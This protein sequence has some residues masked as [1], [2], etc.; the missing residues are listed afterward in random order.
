MHTIRLTF[1]FLLSVFLLLLLRTAAV[2]AP[3]ERYAVVQLSSLE[4]A[5]SLDVTFLEFVPPSGYLVR[6]PEN[7]R[8]VL[9]SPLVVTAEPILPTQKL[10]SDAKV[11]AITVVPYRDVASADLVDELTAAGMKIEH[12]GDG[13]VHGSAENVA[14]I[15]AV[16]DVMWVQGRARFQELNDDASWLV[17]SGK[18]DVFSLYNHGVTGLGQVGAAADSGMAVYDFLN[19]GTPPSCFFDDGGQLPSLTHRKVLS[20]YVPAGADADMKDGSGHGSHVVGTIVGDAGT[21]GERDPFDGIAYDAR[22]FFQDIGKNLEPFPIGTIN[23]PSDFAILFGGAYDPN[24]DGVYQPASEP[25]THSNS[26]GGVEP[27]YNV[28]TA[29]TDAFMWQHPDFLIFYAAGNQGPGANTVG[30]PAVAKNIVT[31][32]GT[33]NGFAYPNNMGSFSSHGP[34]PSG[35]MK[36]TLSAPGDRVRSVLADDPCGTIHKSGTSM[37]TPATH[38]V[39]LLMRQY[40]WDGYYPTGTPNVAN[41]IH[42]SAALLKGMLM[43]SAV[44]LSGLY[45]DNNG[46]G[47]WPSNGQGWGRVSADNVLYFPGDQRDLWLHDEYAL[48]G[49]AGFNAI[50]QT[51]TFTLTVGDGAPFAPQPLAIHLVWTDY[52]SAMV[53]NGALVNNLD[54]TV[55]SPSGSIHYGNDPLTND[56]RGVPDLPTRPDTINPWEGVYLEMPESG[57]YTITVRSGVLGSLMLDSRKQGFALVATGDFIDEPRI[58]FQF[59]HYDVGEPQF[60]ELRVVDPDA[61]GFVVAAV[62][63]A[64]VTLR[65]SETPGIFAG[66]VLLTE[67]NGDVAVASYG[68]VTATTEIGRVPINNI[69]PPVVSASRN[70]TLSW[71]SAE[72]SAAPCGSPNALS[73]YVVQASDTFTMPL[74]DDAE[75]GLGN[76]TF[77]NEHGNANWTTNGDY[78]TSGA[79][80]FYSG[81][82]DDLQ[83]VNRSLVWGRPITLP[84]TLTSARLTY[85]SRYFNY[86]NDSGFIELS[87]DDGDTWQTIKEEYA[88]TY[89]QIPEAT[90]STRMQYRAIDLS[91][92]IGQPFRVRF[93]FDNMLASVAPGAPGWWLDDVRIEGGSWRTVAIVEG[94]SAEMLPY[95]AAYRVQAVFDDGSATPFSTA[96][97]PPPPPTAV[98]LSSAEA[99]TSGWAVGLLLLLTLTVLQFGRSKTTIFHKGRGV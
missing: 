2:A 84:N 55:T 91:D 53:A 27:V 21:H 52:A 71:T 94:E 15:A 29:Q 3:T 69:N 20:Y 46:G 85:S 89:A 78:K 8:G 67:G 38:A 50:G 40:L 96:I 77:E 98:T 74:F 79:S 73:H 34:A 81:R 97:V 95:A 37:S 1:P 43:N 12:I 31:V 93:R 87:L 36:P 90:P 83:F 47:S 86:L 11:G 17:Q 58:M 18:T 65:E 42:P 39:A 57:V 22:I 99:S 4:D 64:D 13:V 88:A 75:S 51:R 63:G 28:E 82:G 5:R 66:S 49:S 35:R 14:A 32:G 61:S 92:Y 23:A 10:S 44:P 48:D 7:A 9:V 62:D 45:S 68:G 6:L 76:W 16:E 25:R 80:S 24:D 59:D 54:L 26:W 30:Y 41:R 70:A 56:F 60:A 19:E 72:C 33:E